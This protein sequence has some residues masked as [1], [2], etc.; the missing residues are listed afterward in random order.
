MSITN[1]SAD[2]LT[3]LHKAA[4]EWLGVEPDGPAHVII[5]GGC[6]R[7]MWMGTRLS[8]VK[9]IDVFTTAPTKTGVDYDDG[10][11]RGAYDHVQGHK[12]LG[13]TTV[14][15]GGLDFNFIHF[16]PKHARFNART[17]IEGFDF[18]ACQ[19]AFDGNA[20]EMMPKFPNDIANKVLRRVNNNTVGTAG[21]GD[22]MRKK[23][24]DWKFIGFD[25]GDGYA[26]QWEN[27]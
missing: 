25:Y 8:D 21:H 11:D 1:L 24:P 14:T 22:R 12:F 3:N 26:T 15:L 10:D 2:L 13:H 6:L 9:D 7:D 5:A 16:D 20:V 19:I 27:I 17:V 4:C 18:T 23:F